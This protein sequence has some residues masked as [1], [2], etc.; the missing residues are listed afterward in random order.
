M[1]TLWKSLFIL[2]LGAFAFSSCE[3]V[4]EPYPTPGQENG[5][6]DTPTEPTGDGTLANP[7]NSI[8]ANQ[9]IE[10]NLAEGE[11]STETIYIKG[12]VVSIK[13]NF[14]TQY[15]NAAF[16][17][18]EDGKNKNTFYVY[19]ALYLGNVKYT[20]GD[21][22][23]AGDEV[24]VCGKVTNYNGTYETVQNGAYVYSINGKT[25]DG[26]PTTPGEPAGE[27]TQAS[28]YNVAAALNI[29]KALDASAQTEP[30]Y[31]KG[32]ISSIKS[33]ETAQYGNANY[34]ISDD[35]TNSNE[36]YIFQSFYL[37]NVKFTSADQ[38]KVGDEVVIYGP[39]VNYMGNIPETA[40]KG[41]SYI[42]SLNGKTADNG[43]AEDPTPGEGTYI[44]E[45]FSKLFGSFSVHTV[46][47]IAWVLDTY[48]YAKATGYDNASKTT[49]PSASYLVSSPVDMSTS[50]EAIVSFDYILRYVTTSA[51]EAIDGIVNKVLVTDNYTNDP[52]TTNWTD[53]T[54][55]LKEVRDWSS[56]QKFSVAVPANLIGK[57]NITFALYYECGTSSGTWEVK[58]FTV[59]EGKN[60]NEGDNDDNT[61]K[62]DNVGDPN[63]A[64]GDF[65]TWENG[66]PV[67]WKTKSTAGNATLSQSTDAHNGN[68][69]VKV[70][71]A[72]QNKRL[73]YKELNLKP[74]EYTM[75]FYT[76]A[77]G[78]NAG[79]C[80]P[81]YAI[82][83][84]GKISSGNDYIYGDY[85]NDIKGDWTL[86]THNFTIDNEGTYCV[87]IMNS[88]NKGDLLIDDFTLIMGDEIII[89]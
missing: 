38:I 88:K 46:Q 49:T 48:G 36:L 47:G 16:Y 18:S 63:S 28:P 77:A 1:K 2:A 8:A 83:V 30:M 4:P 84:D 74:G 56:W 42:Y 12:K 76:K 70:A 37:G 50:K 17:I 75:T 32:K 40:G 69:S 19:R 7:F 51:G 62:D 55:E 73:S 53:I 54:G 57:A 9:Y 65:E 60:E 67:N 86:V 43:G 81:G 58:N 11:T 87:L 29:I 82:V 68:Y 10:N 59:K 22:L 79:S 23:A 21:V 52:S 78:S 80:R 45:T 66:L 71:G 35:G 85:V 13:E 39:F 72:T 26:E 3:D 44:N 89:K 15:G 6:T 20:S 34:Y 33:V 24:I 61:G 5:G 27:G 64:N 14:T 41:A 31:V 25:A